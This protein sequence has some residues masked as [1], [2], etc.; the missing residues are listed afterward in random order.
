MNADDML[1][2]YTEN[3][4][5]LVDEFE[6]TLT[7]NLTYEFTPRV[8]PEYHIG[9]NIVRDREQRLLSIGVRRHIYH[10]IHSMGP[11]PHSSVSVSS[12]LDPNTV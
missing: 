12:P 5:H 1:I 4:R 11:D 6:L 9:I 10:F 8:P 7:L 2:W 3:A